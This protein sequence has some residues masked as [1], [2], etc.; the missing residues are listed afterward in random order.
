MFEAGG[1]K[2]PQIDEDAAAAL[3]QKVF[4]G[5]LSRK[6]AARAREE[7]LIFIG[8]RP[9]EDTLLDQMEEHNRVARLKT[10]TKQLENKEA[11][12]QAK[13]SLRKVVLDEEGPAVRSGCLLL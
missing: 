7:E 12:E 13:F 5:F 1:S 11:Y 2:A 9:K 3:I 10:K 8:M 6:R 4:R